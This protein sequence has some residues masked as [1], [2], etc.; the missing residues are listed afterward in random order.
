MTY[1]VILLVL[2]VGKIKAFR[3]FSNLVLGKDFYRR[4]FTFES[5]YITY[6]CR[7]FDQLLK[8]ENKDVAEKLELD[9]IQS[10]VFLI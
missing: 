6:Y 4:L 2:V 5:D 3:I 1:P 9:K 7:A 8:E 10:E